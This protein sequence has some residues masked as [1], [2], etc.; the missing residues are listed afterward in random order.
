MCEQEVPATE[1]RT[2][3]RPEFLLTPDRVRSLLNE[4]RGMVQKVIPYDRARYGEIHERLGKHNVVREVAR[5]CAGYDSN[6]LERLLRAGGTPE[7]I[8]AGMGHVQG[9][10]DAFRSLL[11]SG[12]LKWSDECLQF[13]AEG[14]AAAD[15]QRIEDSLEQL[16]RLLAGAQVEAETAVTKLE[17]QGWR[18]DTELRCLVRSKTGHKPLR[19]FAAAVGRLCEHWQVFANDGPVRE[20][21]AIAFAGLYPKRRLD[22]ASRGPIYSAVNN[23]LRRLPR[24]E[25]GRR[26]TLATSKNSARDQ[27]ADN[28]CLQS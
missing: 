9:A 14:A 24:K 20:S 8:N 5:E 17:N 18:F 21:L 19:S 16:F 25:I 1:N 3:T 26:R 10:S 13:L 6:P 11:Q 7:D 2:A 4:A 12:V 23:Y 22:P 28:E 27:V 15:L